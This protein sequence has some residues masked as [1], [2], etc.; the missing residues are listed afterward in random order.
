[1]GAVW[2]VE[3]AERG[4]RV[5]LKR[6]LG[7][8]GDALWR[9]KREFRVVE[10]LLHPNIVRLYELGEDDRG[11]YFTMEP[12]DGVDLLAWCR[13]T[14][15]DARSDE[16]AP[17]GSAVRT[18]TVAGAVDE[19]APTLASDSGPVGA[20]AATPETSPA[21]EGELRMER[22]AHALPQILE[23]LAFLHGHG[24]VHRDLKPSNVMVRRD[25][26]V[27]LLDFGILAEMSG[28][29]SADQG[30]IVGTVGYMA[31]EQI[32]GAPPTP[33][34]DLYSLGCMLFELASGQ[35]P[36]R[37]A[38]FQ[39]MA[40]Q[41]AAEPPLL[42]DVAPEAPAPLVRACAAL[43]RR[44]ASDRL[45][46]DGLA[47]ELL[48]AIGA[49]R[50][51]FPPPRPPQ[52]ELVGRSGEKAALEGRLT[53]AASGRFGAIVLAGPT[54]AGKT[55]LGSW[56]ADEAARRGMTV[57][58][59]R[60]R[61]SERVAFNAVDGAIDELASVL[62][63]RR[64]RS[65]PEGVTRARRIAA[66]A[67]PVLTMRTAE[68]G[69]IPPPAS[70]RGVFD[71]VTE[72]LVQAAH[73]TG[74]L[75]LS[76]DDLQWA[77][78][79]SVALLDHFADAAPRRVLLLA[80]IRD[81]VGESAASRWVE[82]RADVAS[83]PVE[84]LGLDAVCELV[85]RTTRA[86][87]GSEPDVDVLR[88]LAESCGGRPFLAEVVGHAL[89]REGASAAASATAWLGDLVSGTS[90]SVQ[91][92]LALLLAADGWT[93]VRDL[94]DLCG[95]APGEV[96][97]DLVPLERDAVVRRAGAAG[98]EGTVDLYH[99]V[100]RAAVA[101]A[102]SP[103]GLRT[104]HGRLADRLAR[105]PGAPAR[106]RVRHLLGAGR[107]PEA[108]ALA[109]EAARE[110]EQLRA[111]GLA[112]NLYR[113]ALG[114]PGPREVALRRALAEALERG[115]RYQEAAAEWREVRAL[116]AEG[117]VDA[118]LREA[119]AL[120]AAN[121]VSEGRR[122][123]DE[124]LR[125]SGEPVSGRGGLAGLFAGLAFLR[126][127]PAMPELPERP[128]PEVVARAER[129]VRIGTMV[130]Y[131]DPLSGIRFLRRARATLAREGAATEVAKSDWVFA[132]LALFSER[133]RGP[134]PL[135]ERWAA[136][137]RAWTE[138]AEKLDPVARAYPGFLR[139]VA[140]QRDGRWEEAVAGLDEGIAHLE[141]GGMSG[142]FEH[143][144][145]LVHRTQID[146]F[147]QRMETLDQA[148]A[149]FR[150]AARDSDDS[151]IRCHVGFALA[152][153]AQ[154]RGD[155]EAMAAVAEPLAATWSVEEPTFQ[156]ILAEVIRAVPTA[157]M[158][159]AAECRLRL[160]AAFHEAR[161]FR[162]LATMYG[163]NLAAAWAYVEA[164]AVRSG[165][166]R[167]SARR[168]RRLFRSIEAAP[169]LGVGHGWRALAYVADAGGRPDEAVAVLRRGRARAEDLGLR[170][171]GAIYD[172]QLGRRLRG[173]RGRGARRPRPGRGFRAGH[174][175][176][177]ARRGP[178][179]ALT[180]RGG[181]LPGK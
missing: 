111:Y 6:V 175:R 101:A 129:D 65:E 75:L 140:A 146:I 131:F 24:V 20:A 7:V 34:S 109:P 31:P 4:Q 120:L 152:M 99:D 35:P 110:A 48:R 5:A 18:R 55:A 47:R 67:F 76:I 36:F 37:G 84:P 106:R 46:L 148:I 44:E 54:G 180:Q 12:V 118:L 134:V 163:G 40:T 166:R 95:R 151:A 94:A 164:A 72:L 147:A 174:L 39:V 168:V 43:M 92:L 177:D 66:G 13:G 52:V 124:G 29:S 116:D 144:L 49:R 119:H 108:A 89:A 80:T 9:F 60:G 154:L 143:M 171:D 82:A 58:R 98:T 121:E 142:T 8:H 122:R 33:A 97:D 115:G 167:A 162:P 149:R 26:L 145:A 178:R 16:P 88:R 38:P 70:R 28:Q 179:I 45:G 15:S 91:E 105:D 103:E 90:P 53:E 113:V 156:K 130:T 50:P 181:G 169:P 56:L 150:G 74:G 32:R 23:A 155:F 173:G 165:D 160:E 158:G 11:L 78:E 114:D 30:E 112:A 170:V 107:E 69:S 51:V 117:A 17:V 102:L 153:A 77:D 79:D 128:D 61:P 139:G 161:R 85:A 68:P 42:S 22:L 27:K 71:A 25:G 3:D 73:E 81:D 127:P 41:L 21:V 125:A 132:Y 59:G 96:D 63:R 138:R 83:L 172:Y 141:R 10:R 19:T 87:G 64:R 100:V 137:A 136:S 86:S 123:L 14:R 133:R 1:M 176:G 62:G 159:G 57:L 135:A 2:L 93:R 157:R 104:A 126:G